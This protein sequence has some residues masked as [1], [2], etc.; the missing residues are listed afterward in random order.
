[1][2]YEIILGALAAIGLILLTKNM[3]PQKMALVWIRGLLIAAIVY[4]VFALVAQDFRW[5]KIELLGVIIY[6]LFAWLAL[7]KSILFLS[8][9]WGL[10][11]LWD[12]LLHPNGHPGYVPSWYPGACLGFD[13]VIAGYFLWYFFKNTKKG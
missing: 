6:G 11:V 7:K 13:I 4:V 8:L 1:M 10:H 5:L 2:I 12:L 3:D 9:G